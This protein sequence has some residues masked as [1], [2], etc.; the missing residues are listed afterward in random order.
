M[1]ANLRGLMFICLRQ[2]EN[3]NTAPPVQ[4]MPQSTAA[5]REKVRNTLLAQVS[6]AYCDAEIGGDGYDP[7]ANNILV[8]QHDGKRD[9]LALWW[10]SADYYTNIKKRT[11]AQKQ[12]AAADQQPAVFTLHIWCATTTVCT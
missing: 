9:Y 10:A 12:Y 4:A 5:E 2:P 8:W 1:K 6:Q 7:S 11:A 3:Q